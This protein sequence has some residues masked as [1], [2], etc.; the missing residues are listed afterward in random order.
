MA[1]RKNILNPAKQR[2]VWAR[3]TTIKRILIKRGLTTEED[4]ERTARSMVRDIDEKV[5]ENLAKDLGIPPDETVQEE[6]DRLTD[7][8]P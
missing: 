8:E 7:C 5:Y 1:A 6:A 4:F 2:I 3:L